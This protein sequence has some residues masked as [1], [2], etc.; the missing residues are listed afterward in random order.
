L[1]A[2]S[3]AAWAQVVAAEL[4]EE[5]LIAADDPEPALYAGFGWVAFA[6]L[7]AACEREAAGHLFRFSRHTSRVKFA[8]W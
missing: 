7:T 1:K 8:E 2:L 4:S 6:T 5:L 3:R